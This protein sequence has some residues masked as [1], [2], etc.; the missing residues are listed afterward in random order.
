AQNLARYPYQANRIVPNVVFPLSPVQ[1]AP[2]PFPIEA[3]PLT[4]PYPQFLVFDPEL[5]L[6]YTLQWNLAVQQSL[7]KNQ[8]LSVSYVAAAGR[9]LL[10][11]TQANI[12]TINPSFTTIQLIKN[13]ATSDYHALQ[14]QFQRRLSRGLQV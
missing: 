11:T 12:A 7:G 6:P 14:A 8:V 13:D 10:Q 4:P 1:V 5:E 3:L 9:R 2:A